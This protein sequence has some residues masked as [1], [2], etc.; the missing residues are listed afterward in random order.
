MFLIGV[1]CGGC[2]VDD[3][4]KLINPAAASQKHPEY[5]NN[6]ARDYRETAF[7]FGGHQTNQ[8]VMRMVI[9]GFFLTR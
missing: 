5:A 8:Q 6:S 3:N 7:P 1:S 4:N 9:T 2:R